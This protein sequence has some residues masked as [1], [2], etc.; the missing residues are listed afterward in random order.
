MPQGC[1]PWSGLGVFL[2]TVETNLEM[3]SFGWGQGYQCMLLGYPYRGFGAIVMTNT[4][5]GVHQLEGF[6]GEAVA[7]ILCQ[8][9]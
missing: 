9:D 4:D 2:D 3:T 6:I 7:M 1:K 8:N 5:T